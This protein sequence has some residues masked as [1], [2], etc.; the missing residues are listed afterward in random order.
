MK[1]IS[2]ILVVIL[3][4]SGKSSGQSFTYY[5]D[6]AVMKQ[7]LMGEVGG[8]PAAVAQWYYNAFH[9]SYVKT[10]IYQP[11]LSFRTLELN[12]IVQQTP[13]SEKID[14]MFVKRAEVEALN[15]ADRQIDLAWQAEQSK[16]QGKFD[17]IDKALRQVMPSGG[18]SDEK[19]IYV[20]RF[21]CL[22][23]GLEAVK[24]EYLPNSERKQQFLDIYKDSQK[25]LNIINLSIYY[26]KTKKGRLVYENG[27]FT[28]K[29][30]LGVIAASA[31][32][33]FNNIITNG[34][35]SGSGSEGIEIE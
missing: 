17:E 34:G 32:E 16:I 29:L 1:R 5:H 20:E 25:L 4:S 33:R 8:S 7:F 27:Q 2:L 23:C 15:L 35:G 19:D 24:E 31:R 22:K 21:N 12:S 26:N 18:T 14:S 6:D 10:A 13:Y 28:H 30:N 3:L 9:S 11:K